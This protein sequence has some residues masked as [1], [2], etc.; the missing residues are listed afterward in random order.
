M[1]AGL[2]L[3]M[4]ATGVAANN[5]TMR[6][7]LCATPYIPGEPSFVSSC[8]HDLRLAQGAMGFESSHDARL[9]YTRKRDSRA[10]AHP[11]SWRQAA[12]D[13]RRLQRGINN[14]LAELIAEPSRAIV[15]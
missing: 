12:L 1:V 7:E 3:A 10:A 9:V 5:E 6:A 13:V 11:A 15:W 2:A 14:A 8:I 4:G